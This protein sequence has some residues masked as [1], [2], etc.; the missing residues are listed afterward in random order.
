MGL[1]EL[2]FNDKGDL[3]SAIKN[4][5][6]FSVSDI[7]GAQSVAVKWLEKEIESHGMRCRIYSGYRKALLA[8]ALIPTG[9]TQAA[10]VYG[11]ITMAIHNLVTLNPDYEICKGVIGDSIEVT[12][13]KS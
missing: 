4:H 10:A 3:T 7:D 11:G 2:S 8:G 5:E 12:Y 6:N 1:R 13:R 9:V